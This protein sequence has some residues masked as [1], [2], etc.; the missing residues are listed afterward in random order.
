[1]RYESRAPRAC[2]CLR[3]CTDLQRR[4]L[5]D[6]RSK[7]WSL[8]CTMCG[9]ENEDEPVYGLSN[10]K[11]EMSVI[12]T[13][14][15]LCIVLLVFAVLSLVPPCFGQSSSQAQA[16]VPLSTAS[17]ETWRASPVSADC[18]GP[19]DTN[20]H[21]WY[22]LDFDDSQW[23]SVS[24]PDVNTIPSGQD[25]YY[26]LSYNLTG[27]LATKVLLTS[28]D[29]AWLYVNGQQ[30]GHWGGN[31]HAGGTVNN[32]QAD[33]TPYL[34]QG[35]NVI[36]VHV[37]NGA[38]GSQFNLTMPPRI[39]LPVGGQVTVE[40]VSTSA[41]CTGDFGMYSPR[42]I[43]IYNDYLYQRG[44]LF[45]IGERFAMDTELVF[46][47]VPQGLCGGHT[48]LSNDPSRARIDHPD[49]LT[50]RI[51]WEDLSDADFNDL[52][53]EVRL[54][55]RTV[56]FLELPFDYTTYSG[57][58]GAASDTDREGA[59]NA[60]FDHRYP[61]YGAA[62]NSGYTGTVTFHGYDSSLEEPGFYLAYDG[63][64]G[65]DF[66]VKSSEDVQV[67]AA[68]DGTVVDMVS[69]T[70][71]SCYCAAKGGTINETC[72]GNHVLI[73]HTN[74]FT[75]TYAHLA[76]FDANIRDGQTVTLGTPLGV[77]GSTGCS[78][79]PHIHF[80]VTN[81][82]GIAVD[83]FGWT[84]F[85]DSTYGRSG[86]E[87][88]W[89]EYQQN[90]QQPKDGTST[91]LWVHSLDRSILNNR[92]I[93]TTVTSAS[94]QVTATFPVGAYAGPYRI[95]LWDSLNGPE[96]LDRSA[97]P[98]SAFA[99]YA[100]DQSEQPIWSLLQPVQIQFRLDPVAQSAAQGAEASPEYH[101]YHWSDTTKEWIALSTTHDAQAGLISASSSSL[102]RFA[103]ARMSHAIFLP[104]IVRGQ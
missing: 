78:T 21:P 85:P 35:E 96:L 83:P 45:P 22:E 30:V 20:G 11:E 59:V 44:V 103:V 76:S 18:V 47:L 23:V 38:S 89:K 3:R 1:M 62:P 94:G 32:V 72:L 90:Q 77:M 28:D 61:T 58:T 93:S 88:P 5:Y 12:K 71:G 56:P 97:I 74:G 34:Q 6:R 10:P 70:P 55:G 82:A 79:G 87:D 53:V 46:Y 42:S 19:S 99:L 13:M 54:E 7:R 9:M 36:A 84:P 95:E 26:R 86:Q 48:Y 51:N 65:I 25:R 24:L 69:A 73:T 41:A 43:P 39:V 17:A 101:I 68:A 100:Y 63:H 14:I 98:V 50:W 33:T 81:P 40:F 57:F 67:L 31:C 29:G 37:S 15:S 102:G 80:Q 8:T 4:R 92:N 91:Y 66:A 16:T 52:V 60:Y 75:T 64:D 2:A 49:P 27:T 104:L